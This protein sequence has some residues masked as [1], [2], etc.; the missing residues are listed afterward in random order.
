MKSMIRKSSFFFLSFMIVVWAGIAQTIHYQSGNSLRNNQLGHYY[1][2]VS[3]DSRPYQEFTY[4]LSNG[5][6][7]V[8]FMNWRILFPQGYQQQGSQKYPM[9]I[10]LHGAGESGRE[11]SGNFVYSP[12]D[13]RYDNN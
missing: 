3:W 9:I 1:K 4:Y 13:P 6:T 2:M 10:M 7:I 12:S 5:T 11:W 8:E